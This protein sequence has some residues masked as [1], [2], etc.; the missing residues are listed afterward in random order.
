LPCIIS[1]VSPSSP[2]GV[3]IALPIACIGSEISSTAAPRLAK[4]AAPLRTFSA[5][6]GAQSTASKPSPTTPT[7]KPSIGL[8]SASV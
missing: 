4:T 7:R 8:P 2:I 6:S 3:Q 5:T 1:S